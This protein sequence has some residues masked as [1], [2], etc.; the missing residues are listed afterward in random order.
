MHRCFVKEIEI[1]LDFNK[2]PIFLNAD[3]PVFKDGVKIYEEKID[4]NEKID[5]VELIKVKKV[6]NL[7]SILKVT[8]LILLGKDVKENKY[9]YIVTNGHH[10]TQAY[11]NKKKKLKA[12]IIGSL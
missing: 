3:N 8:K 11:F 12:K 10:R 6:K 9:I 1:E 5:H 2:D 7:L 4:N